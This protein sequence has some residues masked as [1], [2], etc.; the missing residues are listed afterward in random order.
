MPERKL[1]K[2]VRWQDYR[3]NQL[4]FSINLFLSF[5]VA[6]L[7]YAINELLK[8]T[9]LNDDLLRLTIEM[10]SFSCLFG[11]L[12]TITRLLDFRYTARK[13][14]KASCINRFLSCHLGKLTWASFWGQII[15][16]VVGAYMFVYGLVY[17]FG[18]YT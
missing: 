5:S 17:N 4:S 9:V 1:E 8:P 3:I 16:Y 2:Y 14:R 12:A 15:F 11:V 7:A 6:S 10:W 18:T 13:L